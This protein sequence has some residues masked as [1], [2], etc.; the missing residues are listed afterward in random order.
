MTEVEVGL[1]AVVGDEHLAVL[2]RVH[3]AGVDVDVR[4]EL[5]HRDPQATQLQQPAER[6]RGETLAEG[7]GNASGHENVLRHWAR[8]SVSGELTTGL[9]HTAPRAAARIPP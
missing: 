1:A 3:R 8:T 6:R 7:A 5:L 4:V 2:E 9:Q